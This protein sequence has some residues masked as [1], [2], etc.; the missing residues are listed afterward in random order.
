[1]GGRFIRDYYEDLQVHPSADFETIERMFRMMAKRY[2]PDNPETG[3]ANKFSKI[4]EAY[5]QLSN[6]K[7][8]A[9]YDSTYEQANE[10]RKEIFDQAIQAE[11]FGDGDDDRVRLFILSLLYVARRRDA[12][13]P[14]IGIVELEK[15]VGCSTQL[16]EFHLWYLREKGWIIRLES[17]EF[18]ITANGV[19]KIA[20]KEQRIG[21]Y[22][23][24]PEGSDE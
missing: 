18:G 16:M 10:R 20:E 21:K 12:L 1:M 22:L 11:G 5:K 17:G 6:P 13:S 9:A 7:D 4:Y 2:H 3:D 19:D 15:A 8:R 14:G 24:L 23:F